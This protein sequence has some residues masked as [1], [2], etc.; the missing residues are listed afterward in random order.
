MSIK[1]KKKC[2]EWLQ[3]KKY[4]CKYW[5]ELAYKHIIEE[6]DKCH[7]KMHISCFYDSYTSLN[8]EKTPG[9]SIIS[10]S[11]FKKNISYVTQIVANKIFETDITRKIIV[12]L[13]I[14]QHLIV[15]HKLIYN[16]YV[17]FK[18]LN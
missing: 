15:N 5:A 16:Y 17:D 8:K 7:R 9:R 14:I 2:V 6:C 11:D 1:G 10:S 18:V 3:Y 4:D 12:G 13:N